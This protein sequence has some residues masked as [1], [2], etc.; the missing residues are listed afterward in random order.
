MNLEQLVESY[1]ENWQSE[2]ACAGMESDIFFPERGHG[3]A[4][5]AKAICA[6][7]PSRVPCREFALETM[8]KFGVWGGL[9]EGQ[10]RKI[11]VARNAHKNP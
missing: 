1:K 4:R 9:T 2:A 10:R 11:I 6:A 8:Q 5:Q 7:C 3:L